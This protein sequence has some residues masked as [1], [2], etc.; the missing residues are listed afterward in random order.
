M[1]AFY[2]VFLITGSLTSLTAASFFEVA[3]TA[4]ILSVTSMEAN[5]AKNALLLRRERSLLI[6]GCALYGL[7]AALFPGVCSWR[8]RRGTSSWAGS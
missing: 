6:L 3:C 2:G 1:E 8:A 7:L 5:L 4:A